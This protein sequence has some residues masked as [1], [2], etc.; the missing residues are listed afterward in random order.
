[1][2]DEIVRNVQESC[3]LKGNLMDQLQMIDNESKNPLFYRDIKSNAE[4]V[5]P[6]THQGEVAENTESD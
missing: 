3:R 1:M 4:P 2:S 6:S 5:D